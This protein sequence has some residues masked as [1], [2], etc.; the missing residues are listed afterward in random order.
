MNSL[1][2]EVGKFFC[3]HW[4]SQLAERFGA[5]PKITYRDYF[6][7]MMHTTR[8][9]AGL[10]GSLSFFHSLKSKL[11]LPTLALLNL[12]WKPDLIH[13]NETTLVPYALAADNL[14]IPVLVHARTVVNPDSRGMQLLEK[15]AKLDRIKFVCI[16]PETKSSL[17]YNCRES[18]EVV[19]N[20]VSLR[21]VSLE[22]RM[23]KRELW[24][25]PADAIVVGQMASLHKEKGVWRILE[26]ASQICKSEPY[27]HFVLAGDTSPQAGLG[28]E[29]KSA[30][31]DAGL[32]K[33]VHLV[34]YEKDVALAYAAFDIALSLFGEFLGAIGRAGYEAPLSGKPLVATIP[35]PQQSDAVISG[36]T[37]LAFEPHDYRG[38][39]N[40]IVSLSK[41]A[42]QRDSLGKSAKSYIGDRHD[43]KKHAEKILRI[44]YSM[45][46][47]Q[48]EF[49]A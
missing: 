17:P 19:Y 5:T 42:D 4:R 31:H 9:G 3:L 7:S 16:D 45:I 15:H 21:E 8:Y 44:Y 27:I 13:L 49:K 29:L 32:G 23:Q 2:P 10:S 47:N 38:V 36:K 1:P 35:N 33:N 20:P 6:F 48:N 24:K 34:G 28:P 41:S 11:A 25:I 18:S 46:N 22:E 30:I 43:P 40:A 39:S 26:I 12:R 14:G 37:G